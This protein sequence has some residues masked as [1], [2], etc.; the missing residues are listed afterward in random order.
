MNKHAI[1]IKQIACIVSSS[2]DTLDVA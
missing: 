1:E 2:T